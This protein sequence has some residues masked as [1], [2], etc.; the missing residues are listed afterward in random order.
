MN[1]DSDKFHSD[2]RAADDVCWNL[3]DEWVPPEGEDHGGRG[4][5]AADNVDDGGDIPAPPLRDCLQDD[6]LETEE[7]GNVDKEIAEAGRLDVT[8]F[9]ESFAKS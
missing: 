8:C 2:N 7:T 5:D 4:K 9:S 1:K 6:I 3:E